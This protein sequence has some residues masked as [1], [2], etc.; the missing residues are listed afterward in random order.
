MHYLK[1]HPSDSGII[2]CQSRKSVDALSIKLQKEG[3]RALPYHAG[4]SSD[5]RTENQGKFIKDDVEIIVATIAFGMGIDKPNV[6][7]VIHCDMPK[8]IEG[9][10]QETGRAGRDG[11][12]S[13]CILLFQ[14]W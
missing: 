1:N 8:S 9:Y 10:Y 5:I 13:E 11:L 2:Y 4:L 12:K 7:Y 3:I 14:L 6:R